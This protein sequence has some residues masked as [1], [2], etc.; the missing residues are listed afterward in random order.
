MFHFMFLSFLKRFVKKNIKM[1][2]VQKCHRIG[3]GLRCRWAILGDT[4]VEDSR[5][6]TNTDNGFIN[7]SLGF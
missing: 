1:F 3:M 2:C 4:S 5:L 7:T 6:G